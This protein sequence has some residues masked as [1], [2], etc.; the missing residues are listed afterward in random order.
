MTPPN[1]LIF[2]F[3]GL[4]CDT[5]GCLVR[6]GKHVFSLHGVEF[7]FQR[8][9]DVVGT[10]TPHNFWV[11]WLAEL[12]GGPV[13]ETEA[14]EEFESHNRAGTEQLVPNDGVVDLLDI[15]EN[16]G[17]EVGVASSSSISWVGGLLEQLGLRSRFSHILT[18]GD[19]ANAKPAPDLYILAAERF[20]TDPSH[21]VALEDSHNGS[22]S[23][24]RA[25]MPVVVVPNEL[26]RHQ[27]LQHATHQVQS[28]AE[29]TP[30]LLRRLR[31]E[32][33]PRS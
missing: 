19:V 4:I 8:W 28:L 15:A 18:R 12:T 7:P 30:E 1:A 21:C 17:I 5:E 9:L 10:A 26:T 31:Q 16:E 14:L 23:A 25:G 27:D 20:G 6:A 3:D 2:D 32:H 11:P 24:I 22:L 13:D 33:Q 29:V